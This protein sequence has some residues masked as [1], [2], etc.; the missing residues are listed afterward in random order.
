MQPVGMSTP[1]E[2]CDVQKEGTTRIGVRTDILSSLKLGGSGSLSPSELP[3]WGYQC[4]PCTHPCLRAIWICLY[5]Q[6]LGRAV[7]VFQTG[8]GPVLSWEY[9]ACLLRRTYSQDFPRRDYGITV[10]ICLSQFISSL[11][12]GAFLLISF[13]KGRGLPRLSEATDL[14]SLSMDARF[15]RPPKLLRLIIVLR[16]PDVGVPWPTKRGLTGS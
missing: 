16:R 8:H 14:L 5:P 11:K 3:L 13:C 12:V 7:E 2:R 10:H 6:H 15:L 9:P 4:S 1:S